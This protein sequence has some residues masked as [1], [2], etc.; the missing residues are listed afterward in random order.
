MTGDERAIR[1]LIGEWLAAS[2]RGDTAAVLRLMTEDVTFLVP[3]QR[4][5]GKAEFATASEDMKNL[6]IEG[7]SEIQEIE[8][9]G[10][11][12]WCRTRLSIIV[13]PPGGQIVKRSGQTLSIFRKGGDG[14]WRLAR[15][16]NLLAAEP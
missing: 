8:I 9:A 6:T 4:P 11:W 7:T 16:A 3:G 12:A 1:D 5:F 2:R 15:D 10:P 14:Q 13:T